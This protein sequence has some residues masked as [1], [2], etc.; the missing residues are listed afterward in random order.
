MSTDRPV[1]LETAVPRDLTDFSQPRQQ[2]RQNAS[3]ADRRAFEQALVQGGAD[4]RS[5]TGTTPPNPFSLLGAMAP[6]T[7][8]GSTPP[9]NNV[10]GAAPLA[11]AIAE[12]ATRL[13]VGDGSSGRREV[14]I[15]LKDDVLPG[16]TVSVHEDEG[17][18]VAAFIC[19]N[20][21]SRERLCGCAQE[22]ADA[23][24]QSLARA[25]LIRITTDDPDDLCPFE[26]SSDTNP[27]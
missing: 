9:T 17:R 13:L 23:L 20:E 6:V 21:A 7:L 10:P 27:A 16:V 18:L 8:P 11:N 14:R 4:K 5:D 1:G 2:T 15:E 26:A 25:T 22:L 12:A 24:A 19:A 3:D